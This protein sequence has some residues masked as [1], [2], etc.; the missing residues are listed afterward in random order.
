MVTWL[1]TDASPQ[2]GAIQRGWYKVPA[3]LCYSRFEV[4]GVR[5]LSTQRV[6]MVVK[7]EGPAPRV[8]GQLE[9]A[10][11]TQLVVQSRSRK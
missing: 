4:L 8:G 10:Y 2:N 11:L 9:V 3:T 6:D 1:P 5:N 7:R